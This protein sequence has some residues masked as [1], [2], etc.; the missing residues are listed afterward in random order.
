[1]CSA[2][3]GAKKSYDFGPKRHW[4]RWVWN[5]IAERLGYYGSNGVRFCRPRD[6]LAVYL[7]GAM[8]FDRQIAIDRGFHADNLIAV[9]RTSS[10]VRNVRNRGALCVNGD[11]L[12]AAIAIAKRRR[13]DVVHADLC[14]GLSPQLAVD[15]MQL[16]LMPNA[17]RC[18]VSVNMMRGRDPQSNAFRS[19]WGRWSSTKHR[20]RWLHFSV[21][22]EFAKHAG[23]QTA[24]ASMIRTLDRHTLPAFNEYRSDSGQTF[25]SV[26][27]YNPVAIWPDTKFAQ[28]RSEWTSHKMI[29]GHTAS[30]KYRKTAASAAA[31]MAH[32]T[33]RENGTFPL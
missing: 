7:S 8:D 5:R 3:S 18:V 27:F 2:V 4:R 33:M 15:I 10:V 14:C 24:A 17:Q 29:G 6:A 31:V 21:L 9:D 16:M 28:L 11:I 13:L 32:R 23:D 30:P 25:D 19:F 22:W 12:H 26:V 1:M 20:G